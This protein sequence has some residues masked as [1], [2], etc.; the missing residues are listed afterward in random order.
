LIATHVKILIIAPQWIGD[1]V[2]AQPLI[3][4]LRAQHAGAHISALAMPHI[5]PVLRAMAEVDEVIEAPFAHGKLQWGLRRALARTLRAQAFDAAYVLPNSIKAA[6]V[7]WMAGIPRRI[8][9]QGEGRYVL[10]TQRLSNPRAAERP[11]MPRFY[12]ALA[13]GDD[14]TLTEPA[15]LCSAQRMQAAQAQHAVA[16]TYVALAPGAEYGPAKQWPVQHFRAAAQ[17]ALEQGLQVLV[18]GGAKDK[19]IGDAIAGDN[20]QGSPQ[21]RNLCGSTRLDD[22]IALLAGARG[23]I[24]NDSGLMHVAAALKVPTLGIYGSTSAHHTPPAAHRSATIWIKREC[25]P[26]YARTCRFGHYLCLH[27]ITPVMAWQQLQTLMTPTQE[28]S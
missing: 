1:C 16:A 12:A 23:V 4:R 9:Y 27:E 28:H 20:T 13:G 3:A 14:S 10:L 7:P 19:A 17:L 18:L 6:L 2:M 8:G 11:L 22:A 15:L 5:A 24:S 26:C 25:S 21:I